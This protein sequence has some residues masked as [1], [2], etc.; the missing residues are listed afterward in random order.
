M[1]NMIYDSMPEFNKYFD[2]PDR[3]G[4]RLQ[5]MDS[6]IAAIVCYAFAK[7]G[8]PIVPIHDSMLVLD[9]HGD[10]LLWEMSQAFRAVVNCPKN[11]PVMLRVE[12]MYFP[13]E[14]VVM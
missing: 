14:I 3:I 7:E 4:L 9:D 6:D 8:F 1:W 2:N 11:F 10:M 13:D 5:R 12:S